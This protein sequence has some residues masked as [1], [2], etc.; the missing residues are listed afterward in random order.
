LESLEECFGVH[1]KLFGVPEKC[2]GIIEE[3][4]ER[5]GSKDYKKG[6]TIKFAKNPLPQGRTQK[7]NQKGGLERATRRKS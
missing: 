4:V 3:E 7:D 6:L 2:F 5:Q 1:P